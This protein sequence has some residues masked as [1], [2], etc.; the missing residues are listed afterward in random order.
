MLGRA[1]DIFSPRV[2]TDRPAVPAA[3]RPATWCSRF[4][5]LPP[6]RGVY[7]T[8]VWVV[9]APQPQEH[10]SACHQPRYHEDA[11]LESRGREA[12]LAARRLPGILCIMEG[13]HNSQ[14]GVPLCGDI[15]G[16][17]GDDH[18]YCALHTPSSELWVPF[19]THF[20]VL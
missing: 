12:L 18:V 8:H 4:R 11:L 7:G 10:G 1:V 9:C 3:A 17:A 15:Q 2:T 20:E 14:D 19:R 5:G 6:H 16:P 13:E